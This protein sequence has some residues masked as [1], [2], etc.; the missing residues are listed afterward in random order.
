MTIEEIEA[1]VRA[2]K[3]EEQLKKNDT[4]PSV[5]SQSTA[6]ST[7]MD[8]KFNEYASS[9]DKDVKK[10]YDKFNKKRFKRIKDRQESIEIDQSAVDKYQVKY[11]REEWFYKRHKDT[12]DKYIKKDEKQK[13]SKDDNSVIVVENAQET[14]RV[15]FAK[16]ISIVWFDL[17]LTYLGYIVLFPIYLFR[18][19]VELFYKMKKSVAVAVIIITVVIVIAIAL[20]FGINALMRLTRSVAM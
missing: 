14:L 16:M 3:E 19:L 13:T 8:T 12:I 10:G 1:E 5:Q 6:V 15:G 11:N 9:D 20:I 18:N 17:F 7:I 4:L 2:K